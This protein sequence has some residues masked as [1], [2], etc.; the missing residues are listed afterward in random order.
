MSNLLLE[1]ISHAA[2]ELSKGNKVKGWR[3]YKRR[4][5]SLEAFF[6]KRVG[7]VVKC[8]VLILDQRTPLFVRV[9]TIRLNCDWVAQPIVIKNDLK[10]ACERIRKQLVSYKGIHPDLHCGNVGWVKIAGEL[11][12]RLFDW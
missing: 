4:G 9:P 1:E 11:V 6:N 10:V 3:P 2:T 12:P 7:W 5:K 8:P